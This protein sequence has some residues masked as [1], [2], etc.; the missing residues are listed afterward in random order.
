MNSKIF[1]VFFL[2]VGFVCSSELSSFKGNNFKFSYKNCGP[3]T[4]PG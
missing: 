1:T 2:L 3:A 4:D